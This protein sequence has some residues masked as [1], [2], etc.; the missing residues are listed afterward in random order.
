MPPEADEPLVLTTTTPWGVRLTLNRPAKLNALSG[1]LVEALVEAV[2]VA[3]GTLASGSS[4]SRVPAGPSR[5]A[6]T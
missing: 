5:R 4:S 3:A 2:D 6:T 1:P